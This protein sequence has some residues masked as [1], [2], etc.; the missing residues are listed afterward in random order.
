MQYGEVTN[1]MVE[2]WLGSDDTLEESIGVL[3]DV[4][5]GKYPREHL[6]EDILDLWGEYNYDIR[7]G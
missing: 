6:K 4:A 7:H 2:Y 3:T 5:N 1:E